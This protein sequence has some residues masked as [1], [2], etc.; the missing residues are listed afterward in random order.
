MENQAKKIKIEKKVYS[1]LK[2]TFDYIT[3]KCKNVY[4]E[5]TNQIL[6]I[7]WHEASLFCLASKIKHKL[8]TDGFWWSLCTCEPIKCKRYCLDP[9]HIQV[10]IK[11]G[12]DWNH[13]IAHDCD[14]CAF[15]DHISEISVNL[16]SN[17]NNIVLT[18]HNIAKLI[19]LLHAYVGFGGENDY[20][21]KFFVIWRRNL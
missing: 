1:L 7:K 10:P 20:L 12:E 16:L 3:K 21:N 11:I 18:Y 19:T 6:N 9:D 8:F 15:R 5:K 14:G 17:Q 4:Y 2:I 13:C